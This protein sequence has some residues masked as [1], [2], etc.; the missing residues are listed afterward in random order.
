MLKEIADRHGRN[1]CRLVIG[2]KKSRM[3][4]RFMSC[5]AIRAMSV[6]PHETY[7]IM[8]RTIFWFYDM[9]MYMRCMIV[10]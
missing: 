5:S 6:L 4:N 7:N 10:E 1:G 9:Y 8:Y 3:R 2:N